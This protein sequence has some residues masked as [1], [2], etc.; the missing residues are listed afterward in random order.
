MPIRSIR[1]SRAALSAAIRSSGR[2]SY[3]AAWAPAK[4]FSRA[5]AVFTILFSPSVV[6]SIAPQHS[7]GYVARAWDTMAA[8]GSAS[9]RI[10]PEFFAQIF[11]GAVAQYGHDR[12]RLAPFGQFAGQGAC[13]MDVASRRNPDQEAFLPRQAANHPVGILGLDPDIAVRQVLVVNPR[14]DR[15]G[16]VLQAFQAVKTARRLRGD[17]FYFRQIAL[18]PAADAGE[19]AA[20]AHCSNEMRQAPARLLD[21]LGPRVLDA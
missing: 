17:A 16:H 14:H 10:I 12:G 18:Q 7:L 21:N 8:Q 13:R 2:S 15:G 20:G 6:P 19:G 1:R 11:L 5:T 3:R 4:A 9:I